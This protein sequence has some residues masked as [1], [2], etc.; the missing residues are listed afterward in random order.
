[1]PNSE[2]TQGLRSV[3]H[4]LSNQGGSREEELSVANTVCHRQRGTDYGSFCGS[5]ELGFL[6]RQ[7]S[8]REIRSLPRS[9]KV[10]EWRSTWRNSSSILEPPDSTPLRAAAACHGPNTSSG[11]ANSR[12]TESHC[13]TRRRYLSY[14]DIVQPLTNSTGKTT[15]PDFQVN[16]WPTLF[17]R[18]RR[19]S[20]H[21]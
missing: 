11:V 8:L 5:R 21:R 18:R 13:L 15:R 10:S 12:E 17:A 4:S 6:A 19:G 20:A 14:T 2:S 3:A 16:L 7:T 1:M 9:N